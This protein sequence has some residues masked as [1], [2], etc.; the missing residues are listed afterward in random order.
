MCEINK[1]KTSHDHYVKNHL[2]LCRQTL[3]LNITGTHTNKSAEK[4][5][6]DKLTVR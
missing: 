5:D 2:R 1:H 4:L 3:V 6:R